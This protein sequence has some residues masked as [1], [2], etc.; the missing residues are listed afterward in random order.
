M[1]IEYVKPNLIQLEV[2]VKPLQLCHL[3]KSSVQHISSLENL[4]YYATSLIMPH[5][6]MSQRVA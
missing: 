2:A 1:T 6:M 5:R 4:Y 3:L